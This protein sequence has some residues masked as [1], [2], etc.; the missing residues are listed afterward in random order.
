LPNRPRL[1]HFGCVDLLR[2]TRQLGPV[3]MP[4][5]CRSMLPLLVLIICGRVFAQQSGDRIL[6]LHL[7]R[8]VQGIHLLESQLRPGK[9]KPTAGQG[10]LDFEAVNAAGDVVH[11]GRCADPSAERIE[12][13]DAIE[14]GRLRSM[15]VER[16][17][18]EF[19]I[20]VP[21]NG[22]RS[23]RF[24]QRAQEP[25]RLGAQSVR[26]LISEIEIP[27]QSGDAV[28]QASG[29]NAK[30]SMILS[31]GPP[32]IRLNIVFLAEGYTASQE[33]SFTNQAKSVLN[34][35]LNVS[36]YNEYKNHFNAFAIFVP[37]AQS[38]SDHPSRNT[39][40]DTYFNSSYGT[41]ALE[42]LITIPPNSWNSNFSDGRG[43]AFALLSQLL[44]DYDLPVILV[45]DT[46]Y[47]GSGGVPAIASA[48]ALSAELALHEIGHSFAG[49]ADEYEEQLSGY[50]DVEAANTTRETAR[51]FIKWRNWIGSDIPVPTPET[52]EY[53]NDVGLFEGAYFHPVGWYRPKMDCRMRNLSQPFCEVCRETHVLTIYSLLELIPSSAPAE[54]NVVVPGGG[55]LEMRIDTVQ[56]A[57]NTLI[58][59]WSIDGVTNT[60]YSSNYFPA[61]F[62]TLGTGT[63]LVRVNVL[64]ETPFVRT[65]PR[66]LLFKSRS[67]LVTVVAPTNVPP[68]VSEFETVTVELPFDSPPSILFTVQ[69]PD[70]P[71]AAIS[72]AVSSSN[73]NLLRNENIH[74]QGEASERWIVLDPNSGMTGETTVTLIVS[75]GT[76]IVLRSF[77]FV[78]RDLNSNLALEPIPDQRIFNGAIEIPL[79]ISRTSTNELQFF[80]SS[81]NEALLPDS[82]ITFEERENQ[83]LA[84]LEPLAG[85]T[86]ETSITID[87]TDGIEV[88]NASFK[89]SVIQTP[90]VIP[91]HP[92]STSNGVLIKYVSEIPATMI[93]EFSRD[94][95]AWT[96]V[97]TAL[98]ALEV[99]YLATESR[100]NER[101]YF[102]VRIVPL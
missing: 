31:N 78:V 1:C 29:E 45:N 77:L 25:D 16:E 24:Y 7:E 86:G 47:G 70:T 9:L 74:I 95:S 84:R 90:N 91:V 43:K 13:V 68:T 44:P 57:P 20:R 34:Q 55:E 39:Y 38:G 61:R 98:S 59:S 3:N 37:S 96:P 71:W 18:A 22:S 12:Y 69:D 82:A 75:D 100:I 88:E 50:P 56:P 58:Y 85:A 83:W 94:L 72:C 6:F 40:R 21:A 62:A 65:D 80:A 42:R 54:N 5:L 97:A 89:V 14:P 27:L 63:R 102:R 76:T 8:G 101:G 28:L 51:E 41:G 10:I 35:M 30:L 17:Q 79:T 15:R 93:L 33:A 46:E 81:T 66:G 87:V 2:L 11:S 67:W 64:D 49:L 26:R 19:V 99:E 4:T 73:T 48:N 92:Q 32:D 60:A 53:V 52:F 23:I 36:P